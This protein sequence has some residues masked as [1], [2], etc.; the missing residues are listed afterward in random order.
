MDGSD[1]VLNGSGKSSVSAK[2]VFLKVHVSSVV[3]LNSKT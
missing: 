3:I 1:Y 2:D